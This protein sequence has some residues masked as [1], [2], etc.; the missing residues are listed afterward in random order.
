[1]PNYEEICD[2]LNVLQHILKK[3]ESRKKTRISKWKKKIDTFKF[4]KKIGQGSFGKVYRASERSS[5]HVYACKKKLIKSY[6]ANEADNFLNKSNPHYEYLILRKGL[7]HENIA[8]FK[9]L[10]ID[11]KYFYYFFEFCSNGDLD[12]FKTRQIKISSYISKSFIWKLALQLSE[13]VWF[14]HSNNIIHM[15]IKAS[16]VL[17]DENFNLKLC[18]F[19]AAID[20]SSNNR[21]DQTVRSQDLNNLS[22]TIEPCYAPELVRGDEFSFKVD[23]WAVGVVIYELTTLNSIC[24]I[25]EV[26]D[27]DKTPSLKDVKINSDKLNFGLLSILDESFPL[28]FYYSKLICREADRFTSSHFNTMMKL[29]P[30]LFTLNNTML[31]K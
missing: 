23:M 30:R 14:I 10:F 4:G 18:D 25:V 12:K 1:M 6:S 24:D 27:S 28:S 5:G 8:M 19:D 9:H 17:L 13:A 16:N 2:D 22:S 20:V 3:K 29:G 15:D 11:H 21:K 26:V 7:K 31:S